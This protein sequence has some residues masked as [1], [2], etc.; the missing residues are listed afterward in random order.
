[1]KLMV[2]SSEFKCIPDKVVILVLFETELVQAI[3]VVGLLVLYSYLMNVFHQS[4]I[5]ACV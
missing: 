2:E 4:L 3:L 1:M 5:V